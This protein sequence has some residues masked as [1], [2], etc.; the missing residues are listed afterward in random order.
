MIEL[1]IG[2]V[3]RRSGLP[4]STL[5][6]YEER[7]LIESAGRR[8]LRRV[9][10]AGVLERLHLITLGRAAG[11]SLEEIGGVFAPGGWPRIDR[12]LLAQKADALER[13]IRQLEV[14]RDGLRHAAACR[15]ASHAECPTFRRI[16]RA[17]ARQPSSA[18]RVRN[19]APGKT[20]TARGNS[21]ARR[22]RPVAPDRRPRR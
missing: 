1:D 9:F 13:T 10:D 5:R 22:T 17:V 3:A 15:A 21:P 12:A 4:P 19:A 6:Y 7:G 14:L 20:G 16:L 18:V 8:G 11:F 2:D